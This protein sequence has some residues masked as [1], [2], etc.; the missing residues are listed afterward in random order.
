M[1]RSTTVAAAAGVMGVLSLGAVSAGVP[2]ALLWAY[3][4]APKSTPEYKLGP[5]PYKAPNGKLFTGPQIDKMELRAMDWAP[6]QHPPAP[7]I[8]VGPTGKAGPAPCG[9][10]H[11]IAG[12]GIANLPDLAGLP[13]E[14]IVQQVHAFQSGER[15]S[16][17]PDRFATQMMA[18]VAKAASEAQIREAAAYFAKTPRY[19][20]IKVVE[21][22]TGPTTITER[23]NWY[24]RSGSG[25]QR[26]DGRVI[27]VPENVPL[28]FMYDPSVLQL[29]YVPKGSIRRG[30]DLV[31]AGGRGGQP[32]ATCH[33]PDLKG[34]GLAPP[35]AGR[36]PSYLARM[37]WDIKSGAR[38]GSPV[39]LMQGPASGFSPAEITDVAAYLAS[40]KP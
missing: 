20:R 5:G 12:A 22:D 33:G 21:S 37:L 29:A 6:S 35:L 13:A 9:E 27:E 1:K 3:S 36:D 28:G 8:I 24:Y 30:A 19:A 15:R 4:P 23:F 32:C 34:L 31:R 16:S 10:C 7:P 38:R 40:L 17:D 25:V 11:G 14:Y 39:A 2:D 26:L 18:K